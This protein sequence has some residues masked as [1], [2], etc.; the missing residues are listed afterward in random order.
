MSIVTGTGN[1]TPESLAEGKTDRLWKPWEAS[2]KLLPF[3]GVWESGVLNGTF[4]GLPVAQGM[5]LEV[6]NDH[7]ENPKINKPTVGMGHVVLDKDHLKVGDKVS[8]QKAMEFLKSDIKIV[9]DQVNKKIKVPLYQYEYDALV[10]IGIN[11]GAYG[12]LTEI[13][14]IV[15]KGIYKDIPKIIKTYH[16]KVEGKL[17][18]RTAEAKLFG[19]GIYDTDH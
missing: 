12:G 13:S 2:D 5:I 4:R 19:E 10:S 16:A 17:K 6:Y 11:A 8:V 9:E 18:R 15:N 3:L 1:M 14:E 7:P